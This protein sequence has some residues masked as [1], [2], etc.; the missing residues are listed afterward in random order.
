MSRQAAFLALSFLVPMASAYDA[1]SSRQTRETPQNNVNTVIMSAERLAVIKAAL[2]LVID[3]TLATVLSSPQTLW[4]DETVMAHS[5]QDSVGASSNDKWPDLVAAPESIIGGLHDRTKHRWQFPFATTAGTDNSTNLRVENFVFF[6]QT[7][8]EVPTMTITTVILNDHRPEWRWTYPI[9]TVFGEILFINDGARLMPAEIRTR[10]RY[11]LGWSMNAFRP[12]PRATDLVEA[13]KQRRPNW[14]SAPN[15][16]AMIT[17]LEDNTT[18]KPASLAAQAALATAF[19][20]EGY[21][22]TIPDF[23]DDPLVRDLLTMTTFRSSYD[24]V[25]KENGQ[26]KTYAASTKSR[27]SIVPTNYTAGLL[28]VTDDSCMRCHKETNRLVSEFYDAL[29]LYGELWGMDGIFT[30]HPYDESRYPEL[31]HELI[32]NRYLN[33]TLRKAKFFRTAFGVE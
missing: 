23:G 12:F 15:L 18:L 1:F 24:T 2:P 9:G 5:Y 20:Q 27:L 29:Y 16:K 32:D 3:P 17:F 11:P 7:N 31:R 21:L 26:Q 14:N 30:F 33:P 6:P 4:Y 22:D 8:G 13:I 19:S 10:T 28:R 25:W